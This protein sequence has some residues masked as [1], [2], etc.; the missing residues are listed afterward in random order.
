VEEPERAVR[1]AL[2]NRVA[3]AGIDETFHLHAAFPGHA[4]NDIQS[5]R[6]FVH[7]TRMVGP[8]EKVVVRAPAA[9]LAKLPH[10]PSHRTSLPLARRLT[11]LEATGSWL[12]LPG[13]LATG[14]RG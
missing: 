6:G 5:G 4:D 7:D 3:V 12:E 9:P 10:F 11:A 8:I 2:A 1:G 13:V 14:M